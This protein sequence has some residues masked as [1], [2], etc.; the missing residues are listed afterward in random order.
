M[1]NVFSGLCSSFS[2]LFLFWSITAIAKKM[3]VKSGPL[4]SAKV[5][6]IMGSGIVGGLAYTFSD[7]FWFSAVEAEVYAASSFFTAIVFWL[8]LKWEANADKPFADRYLIFVAYLMGLSIGVHI[9]NLLAI[10]AIV[11][12]YYFKRFQTTRKGFIYAGILS[13][14]LLG[15]IQQGVISYS[16][17]LAT[18]FELF[19]VNSMGMPFDS[20]M[21][22]YFILLLIGLSF[23]IWW[24]AKNRKP[25]LQN[26][27]MGILVILIGYSS[28]ALI[29]IRSAADPPMDENN[30]DNILS[31][32]P[33]LNREQ[34][35]SRPLLK[36]QTFNAELDI[37]EPYVDGK[38]TYYRSEE[39]GKD[40]YLV[41]DDGKN[42]VPNYNE[43]TC[44]YFPRMYSNQGHHIR[45]YK[46]WSDFEGKKVRIK[47]NEG[48]RAVTKIVK[49]PTF[50][51][52]WRFFIDYQI[53]FS[54]WRYFMWNFAGRQNDIQG[55]GKA[56]GSDMLLH[57]NW[58]S[59]IDFIDS[60][61]LGDQSALPDSLKNNPGR[62]AF[63][64]LPLIL[65]L[66]GMI[67]SFARSP[68]DAFVVFLMFF[69]T[70]VAV[71][72]YL[73]PTP[74]QPRERDYAY[75]GSFYAFAI[76]IGLG[77]YA[78][79]HYLTNTS[80]EKDGESQETSKARR[81]GVIP[82]N[83]EEK[84]LNIGRLEIGVF[85]A[86]LMVAG[87]LNFLTSNKGIANA[88][89]YSGAVVIGVLVFTY[90]VG[91]IIQNNALKAMLAF[92]I[93]IPIPLLMGAEGW[94]DHSRANKYTARD[95]ARNYL[96]SCEPNAIIF[97]NG[98]NDTFP[99]WFVQE[100]EGY[101][102]DV[103]VV[104]L[105]LLNTDWY[106]DQQVRAAYES[107]PLPIS[108]TQD[109]YRQGTR[110]YVY[111]QDR[112]DSP[113][114]L[115]Q[116][117]EFVKSDDVSTKL[118]MSN[119]TYLDYL[120]SDQLSLKIDKEHVINNGTVLPELANQVDSVMTW[121]V[122]NGVVMKAKL[123][124]L[125]ML[126]N[127]N[128]ERPMYF[129]I[130][131]GD[132]HYMNLEEYFQL[133]GLA[134]R[135]TPVKHETNKAETGWVHVDKMYDNMMNNF[136]WGNMKED[137]V[138]L[139]EQTQRMCMNFRNNFARLAQELIRQKGDKE[140]AEKLLDK[141]MEVMPP[142]KVPL[143]FFSLY[144]ADAYYMAGAMEKGDDLLQDVAD[145]FYKELIWYNSQD[146]DK[147][148]ILQQEISR[149]NQAMMTATFFASKYQRKEV[150]EAIKKLQE[151]LVNYGNVPPRQ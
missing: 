80:M 5:I 24:S 19:F 84:L 91:K 52:N 78:I 122:G 14:A 10:P 103:R 43:K 36:G 32:L 89:F 97:T 148:E 11:Y 135:I 110:D 131:V 108:F 66:I 138:Y 146:S 75:A 101:R 4:N 16:V 33:Y 128:W 49:V 22:I 136:Q 7:S 149:A 121:S 3:A 86:L 39:G 2:I 76:W 132:D 72:I 81:L 129:A 92:L 94:D 120:P 119:S 98:D 38:P 134:Y 54:Y 93:C 124:I 142:N 53:M 87:I 123:M 28:F 90:F 69:M 151:D 77:V 139:E 44:M 58:I 20:G 70:G 126:A 73:S 40:K 26:G 106:I 9:L 83:L 56:G 23:A 42:S 71:I 61:R 95:F 127:N 112:F 1:V 55:H 46:I 27:I 50:M 31:L 8:I 141:C 150:E 57:G 79:Y 12:V 17:E 60:P 96:D 51:E 147:R 41:A 29:V 63:F 145:K 25:N 13:V 100:V 85:G 113:Q 130:T 99:L 67:Y 88:F 64:L 133:E 116:M 30:P 143:N 137:G 59:G 18:K 48:G 102:T 82:Q 118:R 6:G 62:N 105:S 115:E 47:V 109:Q 144:V 37:D 125:D 104:N 111:V 107:A 114:P 21:W 15:I 34:Y 68:K 45:A 117:M 65:G 74:F 35:G 140:R